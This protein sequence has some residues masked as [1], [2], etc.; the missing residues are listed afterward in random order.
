M[1]VRDSPQ[2]DSSHILTAKQVASKNR[3]L[4]DGNHLNSLVTI[5]TVAVMS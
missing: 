5:S 1:L 3:N 4:A 2:H